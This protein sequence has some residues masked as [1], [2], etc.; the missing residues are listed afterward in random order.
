MGTTSGGRKGPTPSREW[1][2]GGSWHKLTNKARRYQGINK[3]EE[4]KV[5]EKTQAGDP[6]KVTSAT[7]NAAEPGS[8]QP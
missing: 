5:K 4:L 2:A 1:V 8:L 7:L 6:T 3:G